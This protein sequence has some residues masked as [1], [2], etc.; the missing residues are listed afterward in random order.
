LIALPNTLLGGEV[1]PVKASLQKY[2]LVFKSHQVD[3]NTKNNITMRKQATVDRIRARKNASAALEPV[4]NK[5]DPFHN[6]QTPSCRILLQAVQDVFPELQQQQQQQQKDTN[7]RIESN[8]DNNNKNNNSS[9]LGKLLYVG[10]NPTVILYRIDG[11]MDGWYDCKCEN[12]KT[13]RI[14]S[15]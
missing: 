7:H 1:K 9:L 8:G 2:S 5:S 6:G 12:S 13:L 3:T 4:D 14:M 10:N 11:W 15:C